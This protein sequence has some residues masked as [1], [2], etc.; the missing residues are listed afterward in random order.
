MNWNRAIDFYCERNDP[1]FWAEPINAL[2]NLGFIVA[3]L[4]GLNS[5][6]KSKS[7]WT[8]YL[9]ILAMIVGLGSFLFHTYAQAWSHL[10]DV[11]PI[12][13]FMTSF[14]VFVLRHLFQRT[15]LLSAFFTIAFF[16]LCAVIEIFQPRHLLNGSIGYVHA[17]SILFFLWWVLRKR[18]HSLAYKF[19]QALSVFSLGLFFRTIDHWVCEYINVGTHFFWHIC[20][21]ILLVILLSIVHDL[22][23]PKHSS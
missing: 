3:A 2:S 14:L 22:T 4:Y 5:Y 16:G 17:L 21:A 12:A 19:A 10:A 7:G 13:I 6:R 18:Q 11:I 1:S 15:R 9:S 20:N 8:L 23:V